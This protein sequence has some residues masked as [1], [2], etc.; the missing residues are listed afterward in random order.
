VSRRV[1]VILAVLITGVVLTVGAGAA[2]RAWPADGRVPADDDYLAIQQAPRLPSDPPPGPGASTGSFVSPCGVN[3]N[4]H[5]NADNVITSPG[6]PQGAQHGHEYVGNVSTDAYST[7]SSLAAALTTCVN[8]DLST[9]SWPVLR[10][11]QDR[12]GGS[13]DHQNDGTRL[14]PVSVVVE[15]T[16][17]LASKIV[18]MPRFLRVVTGNARAVTA[19]AA[20]TAT[21]AQWSCAGFPDRATRLYPLCPGGHRL[22]RTFAFPSCW[23]GRRNDSPSHREHV[24]FATPNGVCPHDTYPIPRLR[25][26]VS[27]AVPAGRA[28]AVD[29]APEQRRSPTTDHADFINVMPDP[30]M[31]HVVACLNGGQRC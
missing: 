27:Y 17:N 8:G 25:V 20:S 6:R 30:L 24:V 26:Q 4:G 12:S 18:A 2:V 31:A 23:D 3:T 16:G 13:G 21:Q 9:Y 11:L 5:L 22:V 28:F 1:R 7:D 15:F 10:A 14:T 19:R 29:A